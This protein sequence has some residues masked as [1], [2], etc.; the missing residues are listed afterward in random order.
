MEPAKLTQVGSIEASPTPRKE[1]CTSACTHACLSRGRSGHTPVGSHAADAARMPIPFMLCWREPTARFNKS[2]DEPVA[3]ELNS[4][5]GWAYPKAGARTRMRKVAQH[6][7]CVSLV[8]LFECAPV[9]TRLQQ[10]T[11]LSQKT[12]LR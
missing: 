12:H 9:S 6:F 5:L 8:S 10:G 1:S 11:V 2:T 3:Y 7:A 4:Q